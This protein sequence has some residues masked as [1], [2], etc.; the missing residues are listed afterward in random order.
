MAALMLTRQGCQA[1]QQRLLQILQRNRWDLFLTGNYRSV[2]YFSGALSTADVPAL[3]ALWSDGHTLAV[4]AAGS[5]SF[6]DE[7]IPLEIYSIQRTIT[8]PFHDAARLLRHG[9]AKH[10][11]SV[12]RCGIERA[13]TSPLA[14]ECVEQCWPKAQ[15]LD[16]TDAVLELRKR[17]EQDEIGEIRESLRLIKAAYRAAR[18]T[19]APGL[20]E[21]DVYN[22]MYAAAVREAGTSVTFAGDFACGK[23]A[24]K[25]GGPPTTRVLEA[26]DLY[27]LDLFP[28][29]AL[30]FGDTC[31][32]FA[33]GAPSDLQLRAWEIVRKAVRLGE[34]AVRPGV[35]ARDVY[36]VVKDY[37]DAQEISR[38]SF[39][40][41]A[42]HGIGHH[43]H[44]AP[45]IVP[46]T[47]DIFEVGDVITL[48]PGIYSEELRGG[49]RLED[50]YV[51]RENG[52]ENLFDFPMEL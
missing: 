24:I 48:E 51:V 33:V 2:Y 10:A 21:I 46:G 38:K 6:T 5:E 42:G 7:A 22:A 14:E 49:I 47:D 29:P 23:R 26:G 18:E 31:R 9:L 28:A 34:Q 13:T 39:W 45:R 44:E 11:Q 16:A 3:F 52:L 19:I 37:L 40:H 12:S 30:Y 15:I 20:T 32:T 8:H 41:H 1:R 4:T 35:P 50:N 17:K 25:A 36:A 27:I 43:G